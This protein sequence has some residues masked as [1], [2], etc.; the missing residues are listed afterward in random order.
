MPLALALIMGTNETERSSLEYFVKCYAD[1]ILFLGLIGSP[2][3]LQD[4]LKNF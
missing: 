1:K 2:M 3:K 4:L